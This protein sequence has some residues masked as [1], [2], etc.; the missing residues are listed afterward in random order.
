MQGDKKQLILLCA[1]LVKFLEEVEYCEKGRFIS[2]FKIF[3]KRQT[4]SKK[5]WRKKDIKM[6]LKTA[7]FKTFT[8]HDGH[9]VFYTLRDTDTSTIDVR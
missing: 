5:R 2:S 1:L 3:L 9:R 8:L 7:I 4:V 6:V